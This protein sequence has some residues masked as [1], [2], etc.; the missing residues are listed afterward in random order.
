VKTREKIGKKT[1]MEQITEN[2]KEK[3]T[4]LN[5]RASLLSIIV[6]SVSYKNIHR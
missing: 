5:R 2:N 1:K 3:D 4:E 6:T